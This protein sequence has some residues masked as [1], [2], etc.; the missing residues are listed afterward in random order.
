MN[1]GIDYIEVRLDA[2]ITGAGQA[3]GVTEHARDHR[4]RLAR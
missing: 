4:R 3:L 2:S 1:R